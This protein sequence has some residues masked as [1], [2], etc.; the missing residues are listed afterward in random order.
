MGSEILDSCEDF[1]LITP[2]SPLKANRHFWRKYH[3][4]LLCLLHAGLLLCLL[5]NP[6]DG[7]VMSSETLIDFQRTAPCYFWEDKD[8]FLYNPKKYF[9]TERWSLF[10]RD[11]FSDPVKWGSKFECY[12]NIGYVQNCNSS[13]KTAQARVRPHAHTHRHT[14]LLLYGPH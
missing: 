2:C 12:S 6:E 8:L 1:C 13:T 4:H 11:I 10:L 5:F 7:G 14:R 9:V 3:L